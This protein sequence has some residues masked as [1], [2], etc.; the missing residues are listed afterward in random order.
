MAISRISLPTRIQG[1]LDYQG[2]GVWHLWLHTSDFVHG[3]F[4]KMYSDGCVQRITVRAD[5]GDEVVLVKPAKE[6]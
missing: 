1:A 2:G 4:L 6:Q 5:E 3:T